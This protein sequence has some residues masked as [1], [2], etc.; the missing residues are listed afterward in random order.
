MIESDEDRK[1]YLLEDELGTGCWGRIYRTSML[2]EN[3][4]R[5]A[6]GVACEEPS[7]TYMTRFYVK[8][9]Y[10][11]KEILHYTYLHDGSTTRSAYETKKY[12]NMF[13]YSVL[14]DEIMRRGFFEK[15][16]QEAEYLFARLFFQQPLFY[17]GLC[18]N[19]LYEKYFH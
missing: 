12:D 5:F 4:I 14:I 15:Y 1:K 18:R 10:Y 19:V 2:K 16:R 13:T 11:L 3:E 7:F 8:K 6:E 9:H 17:R